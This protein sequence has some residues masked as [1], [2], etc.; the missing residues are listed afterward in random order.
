MVSR[1]RFSTIV[2]VLALLL[3]ACE[4][5]PIVDIGASF[6]LSDVTWFQDEE[7]MFIFYHVVALQ[8]LGPKSQIELTYRTDDLEQP[9]VNIADLPL[10][11]THLPVT[12]GE[13]SLCGSASIRVKRTPRDVGVRLRY[14]HGGSLA[15]ESTVNFNVVGS[16][17]PHLNRSLVLYGVFDQTNAHVQW[18]AR[19]QF[20]TLRNQQVQDLGLRRFFRVENPSF[21]DLGGPVEGNPY[22]YAFAPRCPNQ[23]VPL[24]WALA[25]TTT[26]AIFAAQTVPVVAFDAPVICGESTVTDAKGTFVGTAVAQKNPQTR[27]AFPSLRSP[28]TENIPIGFSIE[29]CERTIDAAELTMQKQRLQVVGAPIICNDHWADPAFVDQLVTTIRVAI[30]GTR[31]KGKDMVLSLVVHHDDTSGRFQ[32]QVEK[33]LAQILPFEREKSSPRLSGAFVFDTVAHLV[34]DKAVARL[35]LWCPANI[36]AIDLDTVSN[37]SVRSCPVL[38]DLP[39]LV[40]GPIKL[41]ALPIL[42]TRAQFTTFIAKYSAAQTGSVTAIHYLAPERTPT[43][44]NLA[45]GD[46][47]LVTFFNNE[48]FSAEPSDAFSFCVS[49]DSRVNFIAV[50]VARFPDSPFPLSTL[51]S[52]H[53]RAPQPTYELG[54]GWDFPFLLRLEYQV[55]L[56][57]AA[58][59]F[60]VSVPF[61]IAAP[62][63]CYFGSQLWETGEISLADSLAQCTRFCEAPTFDSAG[64]YN[65]SSPFRLTYEQQCYRPAY[66]FFD[67]NHIGEGGY[68]LDP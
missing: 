61:G 65:V 29:P 32:A 28:I 1:N 60:S 68:P 13:N 6:P 2:S 45:I 67:P 66:P 57:G 30:D 3:A 53:T 19:H 50:R 25:A 18:R 10:V 21:G 64:V 58:S 17:P 26:R 11:H 8:G 47:G 31:P 51:P 9:W 5:V 59:A 37:V 39:D 35:A 42:P 40:L 22:G 62:N 54:I 34:T 46:F 43:S 16:G 33:A 14:H 20:P 36:S 27:P 15:S 49:A 4:K 55:V 41:S 12:C 48:S 38:P 44:V 56:A 24:N 52:F 63:K 7:T 23:F